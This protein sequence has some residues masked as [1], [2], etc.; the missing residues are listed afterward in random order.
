MSWKNQ[1][2][3]YSDWEH[4]RMAWSMIQIKIET[5]TERKKKRE[6]ELICLQWS[7]LLHETDIIACNILDG[8][9]DQ[10]PSSPSIW[11]LGVTLL[12]LLHS[13]PTRAQTHHCN[14]KNCTTNHATPI[15][16]VEQREKRS[17]RRIH[18]SIKGKIC[19]FSH[20]AIVYLMVLLLQG[21]GNKTIQTKLRQPDILGWEEYI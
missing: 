17:R 18:D 11:N 5:E 7:T 19:H 12:L 21:D 15:H 9:S 13:P 1:T 4:L 14:A 20:I 6:R 10:R 8:L 16:F 2:K 3:Y